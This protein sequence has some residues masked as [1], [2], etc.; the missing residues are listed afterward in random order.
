MQESEITLLLSVIRLSLKQEPRTEYGRQ[1]TM[2]NLIAYSAIAMGTVL[3]TFGP[4]HAFMDD[5]NSNHAGGANAQMNGDAEGRGVAT[6]SMNFSASANTKANFDADG[7]GSM[8]NMFSGEN[9]P[10]YYG[11]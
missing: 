5:N 10:Y 11:K 1:K 9:T 8:Q 6:F 3:F 7:E 2:K 4:A